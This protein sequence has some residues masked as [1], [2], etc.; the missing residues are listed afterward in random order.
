MRT[1]L[2]RTTFHD[3]ACA[4]LPHWI[5]H[6]RAPL[7]AAAGEDIALRARYEIVVAILRGLGEM[8]PTDQLA[9]DSCWSHPAR[10]P[11]IDSITQ[12]H[13]GWVAL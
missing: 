9:R 10:T 11:G 6:A 1:P 8:R 7:D 5:G 13:D 3:E 2:R 4:D 12:R